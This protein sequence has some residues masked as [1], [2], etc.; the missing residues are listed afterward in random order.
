MLG[1]GW[2]NQATYLSTHI[3]AFTL[4]DYFLFHEPPKAMSVWKWT[5][6]ETNTLGNDFNAKENVKDKKHLIESIQYI[7]Q[8]SSLKAKLRVYLKC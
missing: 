8:Q 4:Q 6:K 2:Q 7:K 5:K 3:R 1:W